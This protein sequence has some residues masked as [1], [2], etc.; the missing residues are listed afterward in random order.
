MVVS[1]LRC[2]AAPIW[3]GARRNLDRHRVRARSH[4]PLLLVVAD[5]LTNCVIGNAVLPANREIAVRVHFGD[6]LLQWRALDFPSAWALEARAV[7]A[8]PHSREQY[9][10]PRYLGVNFALHRRHSSGSRWMR[11]FLPQWVSRVAAQLGQRTRRFSSLLSSRTPLRWS[12]IRLIG[13]RC[14][15]SSWPHDSHSRFFRSAS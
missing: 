8:R 13:F 14:Q 12:S 6:Q 2:L 7:P 10:W 4:S 5:P 9:C 11:F 15:I 1:F 3:P